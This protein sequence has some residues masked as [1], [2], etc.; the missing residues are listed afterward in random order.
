M[1]FP[2]SS[3]TTLTGK[4]NRSPLVALWIVL[5]SSVTAI[6]LVGVPIFAW[7]RR[8]NELHSYRLSPAHFG[9]IIVILGATTHVLL[10]VL[11]VVI[12]GVGGTSPIV[13][14]VYLYPYTSISSTVAS[15]VLPRFIRAVPL[16]EPLDP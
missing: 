5:S 16:V 3:P 4:T 12:V 13:A 9:L 1:C 15:Y 11:L 7:N 2:G 10:L 8:L 6:S 14:V